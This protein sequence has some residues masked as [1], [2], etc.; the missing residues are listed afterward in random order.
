V[1]PGQGSGQ[2]PL[3]ATLSISG[4]NNDDDDLSQ[5]RS[6]LNPCSLPREARQDLH[7]HET[8]PTDPH[9]FEPAEIS[10]RLLTCMRTA[11]AVAVC[12]A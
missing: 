6:F 3:H 9:P 10:R 7:A 12:A 2:L 4:L 8:P 1:G 5:D 11:G